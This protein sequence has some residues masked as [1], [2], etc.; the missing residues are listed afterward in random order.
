MF[1]CFWGDDFMAAYVRL[2]LHEKNSRDKPDATD[3]ETLHAL[4][5]KK[6]IERSVNVRNIGQQCLPTGFYYTEASDKNK[7]GED[8]NWAAKQVGYP[9]SFVVV[10]NGG[11]LVRNLKACT[12]D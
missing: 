12:C 8:I 9:Y 1:H 6:K 5:S 4:L 11:A 3:Y 7:I 2:E 10:I